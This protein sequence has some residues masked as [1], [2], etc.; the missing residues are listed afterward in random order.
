MTKTAKVAISTSVL[1]WALERS[2]RASV[3]K[4]KFPKLS[5]WL[6]GESMP[7]LKQLED[8]AKATYT[9]L[10]YFFLPEPPVEQLPVPYFRTIN[11]QPMRPFSPELIDTVQM[12]K[13]RQYWMRD[14]LIE[15]GQEPLSFVNSA[16]LEDDPRQ[17]ARNIRNTLGLEEEWAASQRNWTEALR[18]L[19]IKMEDIGIIVVVN[20]IVGN[21]TRRKLNPTEFRGFVLIDEYAPLVFVNGADGKAAQMF[22]LAHELAHVWFGI[23]AAFD[24]RDLQ[25]ADDETEKI[26]NIVAAEFLVPEHKFHEVWIHVS[27]E[28]EP[29]QLL[30]RHFKVSELVVARRALDLGYITK[31]EFIEFYKDYQAKERLVTQDSEGGN[32]Y[33]IQNMRVGRR[34]AKAVVCAVREG[35]LLYNDAYRLT[36]LYGKAFERYAEILGFGGL[37]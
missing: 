2:G 37:L 13:L 12:M 27:D 11:N 1:L 32:F 4:R 33:A 20:S 35:K 28:S 15:E 17:V 25:P 8:L 29:F 9:P 19:Q 14:Y 30:A 16:K 23:S 34:F 6:R 10:G 26:C 31:E 21:N 5:Q 24:L 3:V 7:T 18:K 36:G 22:T